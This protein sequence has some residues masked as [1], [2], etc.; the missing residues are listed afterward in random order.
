VTPVHPV[1]S[2]E[3]LYE[4]APCGYLL[5]DPAGRILRVNRTFLRW[6]ALERDHL[7][8]GATRVQDLLTAG[9]RVFYEMQCAPLLRLQGMLREIAVDVVCAD[10]HPIPVLMNATLHMDA[11][12][13]PAVVR[14]TL[15]DAT[16]RRSYELALAAAR[17]A[18]GEARQRAEE[19]SERLGAAN[20]E[21]ERLARVDAL[22]EVAN[23]RALQEQLRACV[24]RAR[25]HGTDF[26]V[27][28]LDVDHFKRINDTYG[29][30]AGDQ[31]LCT[32]AARMRDCVRQEDTVGRW[33][34][35]EFLVIA[36]DT[37]DDGLA[38]LCERTRRAINGT[39]I[40]VG[41]DTISVTA[42]L[43]CATWPDE[44]ADALIRRADEALYRAKDEGRDRFVLASHVPKVGVRG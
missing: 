22:T 14:M 7:T 8:A 11:R 44:S 3:E 31:V 43:G 40:R 29:H 6:T 34:G 15:F 33:G 21:L 19:L 30:E 38:V 42:S 13:E 35:E 9:S 5:T 28:L 41:N 37:S 2:A 36:A 25:R 18:E 20:A 1:E 39:P 12:G 23:R 27:A 24:A 16:E 10:G 32:I 17:D 4:D 26:G